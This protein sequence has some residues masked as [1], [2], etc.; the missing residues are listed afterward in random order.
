MTTSNKFK[1]ASLAEHIQELLALGFDCIK[2]KQGYKSCLWKDGALR[3]Q[4]CEKE[5]LLSGEWDIL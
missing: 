3:W 2:K 4:S 5:E 1:I